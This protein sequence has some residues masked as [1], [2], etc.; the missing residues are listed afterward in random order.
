M[1]Q[2]NNPSRTTTSVYPTQLPLCCHPT[3]N[4][5]TTQAS[6]SPVRLGL[7]PHAHTHAY[8]VPITL[9]TVSQEVTNLRSFLPP[10]LLVF[11]THLHPQ[12][13]TYNHAVPSLCLSPRQGHRILPERSHRTAC[14][15]DD[16]HVATRPTYDVRLIRHTL[17][18]RRKVESS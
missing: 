6:D 13:P 4:T 2:N 18:S 7:H 8:H 1:S 15:C 5:S 10:I 16:A 9:S 17:V 12:Q 14:L 11:D 3:L